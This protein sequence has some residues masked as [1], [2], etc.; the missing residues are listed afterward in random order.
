MVEDKLS[1]IRT[2][3]VMA[4]TS[5]KARRKKKQDDEKP[6]EKKPDLHDDDIVQV[7]TKYG[8]KKMVTILSR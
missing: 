8:M 1:F 4:S 5:R 7:T 2:L 6:A 3:S